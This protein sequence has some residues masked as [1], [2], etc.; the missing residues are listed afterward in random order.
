MIAWI[1][2][3]GRLTPTPMLAAL[4]RPALVVA[5]DGGARHAAALGVIVDVW[6]GDFDSSAGVHVDA[7][8]EVHPAAKDETDAELAVRVALQRGATALV[9]IGAFGGRFDHT[10]ALM[11][12]GIRRAREGWPVILTSG[13][14]WGWPLL[15][16]SPV[17]LE[18]EAN[19]TLSV[20]AFSDLRGLSLG[21]VRWPLS[22]ADV[23][24]GSGWTVSNETTGAAIRA[25]LED[26][27][28]LVTVLVGGT[29]M[30]GD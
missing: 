27:W 13:D 7:P 29:E 3:G 23:P 16:A 25:T 10:A 22:R 1:L 5:A 24:L 11:L 15:P 14:E 2:V 8:R 4:P 12:G 9:F 19:L 18:L 30:V 6:V 20:L 26:G 28:A 21:G 17:A